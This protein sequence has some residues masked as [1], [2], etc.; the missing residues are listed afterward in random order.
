MTK[1][2]YYVVWEGRVKGVF[3]DWPT[4]QQSVSGHPKAKHKSFKT[5]GEAE[6]AF[7]A[8]PGKSLNSGRKST[9]RQK[10]DTFELDTSFDIH[11]FCDGGCD[12]N[13]GKSGSGVV[14][15]QDGKLTALYYGLY[16]P[17]GTNNTAELNALHQSM[18]IARDKLAL[19]LKVQ[20]LADSTYAIKAMTQWG[21]GWKHRGWKRKDG[22]L[23][24]AALIATMYEEYEGIQNAVSIQ[25]VKAHIGT[26]GNELAD[27]LSMITIKDKL[28]VFKPYLGGETID[29]LLAMQ[30]G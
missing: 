20:I 6:A 21:A 5:R 25:H 24:N 8:S 27:R 30:S 29:E 26:E 22:E 17:H 18:C 12:P 13:P 4:V 14:V 7:A 28:T 10:I 3:T 19:G 1:Q 2:K 16:N 11:I 15:Y 23:A 9:S